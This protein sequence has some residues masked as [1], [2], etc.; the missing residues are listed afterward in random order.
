[1]KINA[2]S[3][4]AVFII[5]IS[6]RNQKSNTNSLNNDRENITEY[7]LDSNWPELADNFQLGT[8]TG[9]DLDSQGNIFVF[10]SGPSRTEWVTPFPDDYI[11][12][13]TIL[14]LDK[15][16]GRILATW[17]ANHFIMPHGLTVDREDNVWVTD[18][19]RNQVF[20]YNHS[21]KLL[22]TLGEK[23]VAGND[24]A[25]FDLPTDVAIAKDGSIYVS[26]GYGNSRVVKFTPG[27]EYIMEWGEK[28]TNNGQFNIPHSIELDM[29][30]NVYIADR[31][32]NRIQSFDP[33]GKFLWAWTNNDFGRIFSVKINKNTNTLIAIDYVVKDSI[34]KGSDVII[35]NAKG[36][37][38]SKFGRSG[39]YDGVATWYHDIAIDDEGVI[40]TVDIIG[41]KIERFKR[42]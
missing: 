2:I 23:Q 22:M 31:E 35:F 9:I 41:K 32:N 37:P 33:K 39:N 38:T 4:I 6:C 29:E 28:G 18:V 1:M 16:N 5:L 11:I 30:G 36:E 8:P 10:H 42:K 27:G 14:M 40:Y 25:H 13:E 3:L 17:G 34:P 15:D 19:A 21:G 7:T 24:R 12:E 20:K 26:D